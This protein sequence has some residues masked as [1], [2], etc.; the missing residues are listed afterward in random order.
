MT[1]DL[2]SGCKLQ[3]NHRSQQ[4]HNLTSITRLAFS[5]KTNASFLI[6]RNITI[7]YSVTICFICGGAFLG[8]VSLTPPQSSLDSKTCAEPPAQQQLRGLMPLKNQNNIV[9]TQHQVSDELLDPPGLRIK[10]SD[11]N[12]KSRLLLFAPF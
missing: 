9:I 5:P 3:N 2:W 7:Q 4:Q 12:F 8:L 6:K 11:C 1:Y 10:M